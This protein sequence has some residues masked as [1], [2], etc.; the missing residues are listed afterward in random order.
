MSSVKIDEELV[1]QINEALLQSGERE[2]LKRLVKEK[3]AQAGW[4]DL[5]RAEADSKRGRRRRCA[6]GC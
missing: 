5:V 3:L 1:R 4:F 2:R 6:L